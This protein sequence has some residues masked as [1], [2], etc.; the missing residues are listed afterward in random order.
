MAES[1]SLSKTCAGSAPE[2]RPQRRQGQLEPRP[3]FPAIRMPR[4]RYQHSEDRALA[5]ESELSEG[6][7]VGEQELDAITDLL[8]GALD[9][10]LAGS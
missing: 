8:G 10:L 9:D 1:R 6:M 3:A 5:V 2:E 7:V 4:R